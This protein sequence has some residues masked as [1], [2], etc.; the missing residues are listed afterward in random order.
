MIADFERYPKYKELYIRAFDKM[1][2]NHPGEI[3]VASGEMVDNTTSGGGTAIY[4]GWVAW[5]S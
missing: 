3:K 2:V 5:N 1:I 4:T